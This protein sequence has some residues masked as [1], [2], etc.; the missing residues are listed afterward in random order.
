MPDAWISDALGDG[1]GHRYRLLD[2]RRDDKRVFVV[3]VKAQDQRYEWQ[4]SSRAN[5]VTAIQLRTGLVA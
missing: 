5:A 4:F 3:A 1:I 2:T